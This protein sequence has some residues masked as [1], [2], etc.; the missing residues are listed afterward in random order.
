MNDEHRPFLLAILDDPA[1]A[2]LY[3]DWLDEQ[4]LK[5]G[6]AWRRSR[7]PKT[8][9]FR[10]LV[11]SDALPNPERA[12]LSERWLIRCLKGGAVSRS[13]PL[14][15]SIPD[16]ANILVK[17]LHD[18][19]GIKATVVDLPPIL[20]LRAKAVRVGEE[21]FTIR[22]PHEKRASHFV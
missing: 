6:Y 3:A 9:A 16:A 12:R 15:F 4:Q 2:K 14:R 18:G 7:T 11:G 13:T 17:R 19:F 21:W 20:D 8:L 22:E 10:A 1:A 5:G